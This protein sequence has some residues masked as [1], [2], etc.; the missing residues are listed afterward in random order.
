M[1]ELLSDADFFPSTLAVS[2]PPS[3]VL[4]VT[5]AVNISPASV[6][7]CSLLLSVSHINNMNF[8]DG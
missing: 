4:Y 3:E 2:L 5:S 8:F 6:S 7:S 1:D